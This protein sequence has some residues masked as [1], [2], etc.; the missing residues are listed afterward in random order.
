MHRSR[1]TRQAFRRCCLAEIEDRFGASAR[2][3]AGEAFG[4]P[5]RL[6]PVG[7]AY[8]ADIPAVPSN[9]TRAVE[10]YA[11]EVGLDC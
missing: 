4:R 6:D 3:T 1:D 9:A 11:V 2:E 8:L 7:A 5:D 10:R